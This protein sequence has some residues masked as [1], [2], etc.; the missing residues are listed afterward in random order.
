MNFFIFN[1]LQGFLL[2]IWIFEIPCTAFKK[3]YGIKKML[4]KINTISCSSF[5]IF[6]IFLLSRSFLLRIWIFEIP[7]T[8]FKKEYGIKKMLHKINTISCSSFVIFKIFLL[9]RSHFLIAYFHILFYQAVQIS[10]D[11]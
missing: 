11:I 5:V 3:E 8:A 4:H 7:C 6:K 1:N 2:R 10:T 9:S